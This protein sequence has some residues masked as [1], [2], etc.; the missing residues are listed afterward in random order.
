MA[1]EHTTQVASDKEASST[2]FINGVKPLFDTHFQAETVV[3]Y[4]RMIDQRG[5]IDGYLQLKSNKGLIP[6]NSRVQWV[7]ESY[8]SFTFRV[9]K[10]SG[11]KTELTKYLEML[12][13]TRLMS[14]H[15]I[16]QSFF[17]L[18][19][20]SGEHLKT[21]ITEF[22]PL[23]TFISRELL[24][25]NIAETPETWGFKKNQWGDL[26]IFVKWSFLTENN[27][28]LTVLPFLAAL[29]FLPGFALFS[30]LKIEKPDR[31]RRPSGFSLF[32]C[33]P[34]IKNIIPNFLL[35]SKLIKL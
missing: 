15:Y 18:P 33:F 5:L 14:P 31:T 4:D 6:F 19:K 22:E 32:E 7:K 23:F 26:F 12:Q 28:P 20:G 29:L 21:G 24:T 35:M 30:A 16:S 17:G 1:T 27:V 25:K 13:D 11:V 9:K 8:D 3:Q 34:A 2:A 10:V